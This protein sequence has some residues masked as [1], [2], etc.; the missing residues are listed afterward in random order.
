MSS[1]NVSETKTALQNKIVA[2]LM[3]TGSGIIKA[4]TGTG[5]TRCAIM[6]LDRKNIS[7]ALWVVPTTILRD[8]TIP[9]EF[10]KWSC[11]HLLKKVK[12]ICYASLKKETDFYDIVILDEGHRLTLKAYS[13]SITLREKKYDHIVYMT[14]TLPD[15]DE[16]V[17]LLNHLRLPHVADISVNDA[18]SMDL[19][20]DFEVYLHPQDLSKTKMTTVKT[21]RSTYSQTEFIRYR[22]LSDQIERYP[23]GRAPKILYML[24]MRAIYTFESK[25]QAAKD[26][27]S[28][29]P[30][31]KRVLIF[32]GSIEAADK[33]CPYTYHSKTNKTDYERFNSHQINQLA[34]VNALNEGHNMVDVDMAV[35]VQVNSKQRNYIQRQGRAIR[36]RKGH[37]AEIH[38]FYYRNTSD[39]RW[40]KKSLKE[41][42]KHKIKTY[43][44]TGNAATAVEN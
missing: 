19:V 35:M 23:P 1:L 3:N 36:W 39:L 41:I 31:S 40:V 9:L 13:E 24:R 21:K 26:F 10:N 37:K 17:A 14:A 33:I 22:S 8:K 16:K 4:A 32:C 11:G 43:A 42:P 44:K 15:E 34:V 20:S 2:S 27:I 25:I 29:I 5:K 30:K 28:T 12:I 18:L 38:V 7:S 6:Y